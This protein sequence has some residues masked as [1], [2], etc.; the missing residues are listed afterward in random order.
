MISTARRAWP[1][2]IAAAILIAATLIIW[3]YLTISIGSD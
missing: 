3:D 2:F 1:Y